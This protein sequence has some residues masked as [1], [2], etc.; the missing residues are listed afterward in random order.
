MENNLLNISATDPVYKYIAE[1]IVEHIVNGLA[2]L[3]ASLPEI[4]AKI[5]KRGP[6]YLSKRLISTTR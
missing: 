6:S 4:R 5:F 2:D 3:I 1:K